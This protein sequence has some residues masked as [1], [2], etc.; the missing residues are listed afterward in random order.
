MFYTDYRKM[1][2][3]PQVEIVCVA[4]PNY[5]HKKITIDALKAHKH[6]ICEKPMTLKTLDANEMILASQKSQGYLFIVKQNR[7]NPPVVKVKQWLE[8]KKLGKIGL[9]VVNCFWNRNDQ[10][11]LASTWKG[12]KKLD[13][14]TLFTQFSHFV[15]I[16]YYLLGD[17][18]SVSAWGINFNHRGLIEFEDT[19]V[20]NFKLANQAL[21]SLSYTTSS[22][23][24]NMEGSITI[25]GSKGTVK[26]GGQYLNSLDYYQVKGVKKVLLA[27]GNTANNYGT[28][29][30]SMSNHDQ[31]ISNVIDTL[32]HRARIS[33]SGFEGM[34]VVQIIE[35]IYKSMEKN[36]NIIE[37]N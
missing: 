10:Y 30:G 20:I 31:I 18:V 22:Y 16:V 36:G 33:T 2:K 5:L 7:F 9:V 23:Q 8:K 1:L 13:G 15:D 34:K 26:I 17:I 35:A 6:V 25:F 32:N 27:K 14:G 21:G 4:A 28:Y 12:K 19:G 3:N 37:I 11:Y 29:Q 24:Q